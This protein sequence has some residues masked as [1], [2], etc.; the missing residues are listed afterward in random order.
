MKDLVS[1]I[2]FEIIGK[3]REV[4]TYGDPGKCMFILLKGQVSVHVP[5]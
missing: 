2:K 5:N 3:G 1:A 4:I